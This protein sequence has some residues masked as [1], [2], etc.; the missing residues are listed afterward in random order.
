MR[1]GNPGHLRTFD[2]LGPHAYSLTFCTNQRTCHFLEKDRVHVVLEQFLRAAASTGFA[3]LAYC[4]MPDHVHLLIEG[5]TDASDCRDFI[6]LAKQ[7]SGFHFKRAFGGTL[8]QRYG[9]ERTL[10]ND[11]ATLSV[12]RYILENPVRAGIARRVED[13]P[14][15]GSMRYPLEQVLDAVAM[16]PPS[17]KSP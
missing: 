13:Y 12:S 15:A 1:T 4:F 8:W 17:R 7:L 16:M 10:R 3:V 11:E 9:F 5:L 6:R 14:F 2:Y